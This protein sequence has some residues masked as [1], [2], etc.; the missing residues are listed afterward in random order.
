MSDGT[1][2]IYQRGQTWWI[3]YSHNG[4]RYRES[5]GSTKKKDARKLLQK[6]L[7]EISDGTFAPNADEVTLGDLCEIIEDDYITQG[8]KSLPRLKTSLRHLRERIGKDTKALD[9]TTAR[10][11]RYIRRRKEEDGVANAT[12][13]KE[14]AALNRAYTL[15]EEDGLLNRSPHVP[16][17]RTD[18]TRERFL[19]MADVEA[20]CEEITEPLEPVVRFAA[21]TGWRKGEILDL[22]WRQVDFDAQEIRLDPGETKNR[23]GRVV[24]F[25][26]Y[27]QLHRLLERQREHTDA[28]SRRTGRVV[29]WVFHRDGEPIKTMRSAWDGACERAGLDGAWFHDLRRT[30]VRNLEAAGVPRSVA[31]SITGHKTEAVYRRYAISDKSAQKE[32]LAKLSEHLDDEPAERKTVNLGAARESS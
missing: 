12:V 7:G 22:R 30:A 14:L 27:P 17:L 26:T 24:P 32:G 6:R 23:E 28:V 21:L 4:E 8:R 2:R 18:N 29:P 3:D 11:K 31:T 5:S 10:I 25:G 13:N 16:K 1:G 19:T 15:A 20:I 9:I